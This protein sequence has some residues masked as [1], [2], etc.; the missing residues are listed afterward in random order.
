VSRTFSAFQ[1]QGLLEVQRKHVLILDL[2]GLNR[3]FESRV[4]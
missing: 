4:Q 1:Q 2:E 3:A